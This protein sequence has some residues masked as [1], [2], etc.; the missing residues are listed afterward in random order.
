MSDDSIPEL[1]LGATV[2]GLT[3]GRHVFGRYLLQRILGSGGMG[4]VWL[5]RDEKLPRHVALKFLPDLGLH[6]RL[7]L[8]QLMHETN[9][10]L[11]LTH[12]HIVCGL[13]SC[14]GRR[15]GRGHR[16]GFDC[17]LSSQDAAAGIDI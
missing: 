15:R 9:R 17:R 13:R 7:A 11:E 5:A 2:R 12:L 4:I 1:D 14:S 8:D 10:S 16:D 3:A 6:D